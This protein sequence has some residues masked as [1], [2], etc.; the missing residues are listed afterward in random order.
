MNAFRAPMGL[1][2]F[3]IPR[4]LPP[5]AMAMSVDKQ[6]AAG[7]L[8]LPVDALSFGRAM[9]AQPKAAAPANRQGQQG[10]RTKKRRRER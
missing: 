10:S 8:Y 4:T 3:K 7:R 6:G 1:P 2:L 9:F 5:I